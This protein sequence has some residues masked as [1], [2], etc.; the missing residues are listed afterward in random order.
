MT[1]SRIGTLRDDRD[2]V[3]KGKDSIPF[4]S[5]QG[6]CMDVQDILHIEGLRRNLI[7]L[8]KLRDQR[9]HIT[10]GVVADIFTFSKNGT[11]FSAVRSGTLYLLQGS[12]Q[13]SLEAH[14]SLAKRSSKRPTFG[15]N[16]MDTCPSAI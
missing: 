11:S 5:L 3:I 8:S 15:I 12:V 14:L 4:Q 6:D 10:F 9:Y 13:I 2:F 7:S 1:L 16:N